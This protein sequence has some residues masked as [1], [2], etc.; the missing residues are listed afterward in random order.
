MKNLS[1]QCMEKKNN[2]EQKGT[3]QKSSPRKQTLNF[4]SQ[5]AR[6]YCS[7]N[8]LNAGPCGLVLN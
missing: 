6:V 2:N 1:T 4:L 8:T 5:F 7:E 3:K